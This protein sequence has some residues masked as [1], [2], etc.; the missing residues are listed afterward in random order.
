MQRRLVSLTPNQFSKIE[1]S[2]SFIKCL[3]EAGKKLSLQKING[4]TS[5]IK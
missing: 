3:V 2:K 1:P 5:N 4:N